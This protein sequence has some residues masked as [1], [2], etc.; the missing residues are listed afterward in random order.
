LHDKELI[1]GMIGQV[2]RSSE[3]DEA[4]TR[5]IE[6]MTLEAI[7]RSAEPTSVA[8]QLARLVIAEGETRVTEEE[9]ALS[10]LHKAVA[11]ATAQTAG[12]HRL[13]ARA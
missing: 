2:S 4:V 11:A 8:L 9:I 1:V 3:D 7:L 12:V 13:G 10:Y 5:L 6:A